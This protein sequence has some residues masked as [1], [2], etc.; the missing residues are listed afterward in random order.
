MKPETLRQRQARLKPNI[1][2][3]SLEHLNGEF[4]ENVLD[5]V[6]YLQKYKPLKWC[7]TNG[8]SNG[9]CQVELLKDVKLTI[10]VQKFQ[11]G[12]YENEII[13]ERLAEL[14]WNGLFYCAHDPK[15]PPAGKGCNP[16]KGCSPGRTKIVLGK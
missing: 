9:L 6:A 11:L 4:L 12:E 7:I 10:L 2:E 14:I 8:W 15:S 5:F 13:R 3:F 16:N 1:E